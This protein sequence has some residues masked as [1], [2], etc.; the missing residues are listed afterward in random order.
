LFSCGNERGVVDDAVLGVGL[1]DR[2]FD[3]LR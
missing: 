3:D 2:V 1:A